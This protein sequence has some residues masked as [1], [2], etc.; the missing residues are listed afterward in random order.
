MKAG[1]AVSSFASRALRLFRRLLLVRLLRRRGQAPSR[2]IGRCARC[3]LAFDGTRDE[4][5]AVESALRA[6]EQACDGQARLVRQDPLQRASPA[7]L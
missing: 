4:R 3:G 1:G 7:Y 2:T 6:H 5:M